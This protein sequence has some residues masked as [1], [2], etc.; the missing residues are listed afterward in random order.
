MQERR[1]RRSTRR[2][3]VQQEELLD[4]PAST[5]TS[6]SS[7]VQ[8][9]REGHH[10]GRDSDGHPDLQGQYKNVAPVP[11]RTL[12]TLTRTTVPTEETHLN[13]QPAID[14]TMGVQGRDLGHVSEDVANILGEFGASYD[15]EEKKLPDGTIQETRKTLPSG[16]WS[17]YDPK[18]LGARRRGRC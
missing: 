2:L 7:G 18:T 11:L 6:T 1:S 10:V 14:V 17:T 3:P 13:I 15:F 8:Y 16:T 5:T 4:R 9:P 12:A